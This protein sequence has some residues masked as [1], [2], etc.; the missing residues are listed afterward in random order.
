M[1]LDAL[2]PI[3]ENDGPFATVYLESGSPAEDAEHRIR[4]R[5]DDLRGQLAEAGAE[6]A[7]LEALDGAIM[8]DDITEVLTDGRVLVAGGD[9]VLLEKPWDAALGA[10]DAAHWSSQPE[11]GAYVRERAS[12]V[13][14]LVAITDQEGAVL[15]RVVATQEQ[16][17][18]QIGREVEGSSDA[19][20][21]KPTE[22]A[23]SKIQNR[24]DEAVKRN[25]KD[26]AESLD[27]IARRRGPDVFVLAGEVQGR[28]ALR[29]EL[30]PDLQE[31]LVETDRG[32]TEDDGAEQSLNEELR[33]I[34]GEHAEEVIG[35]THGRFEQAKA[36]DQGV[37]GSDA[38]AKAAQ[39]GAVD[40]LVLQAE[41]AGQDEAR[42]LAAAAQID[43]SVG[44]VA[45]ELQDGVGA[46]LRFEAPAE[47][48]S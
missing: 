4:L 19:P 31:I 33:R 5:W 11:L 7:T 40:T 21:Q 38:V 12:S 47:L 27:R 35:D 3:I 2:K 17:L 37:E 43:A 8:V 46:I 26:I 10:G 34:A 16:T 9:R 22:G 29:D 42:L 18:N 1:K 25:A 28:S 14:M 48:K 23:F 30:S 32:G 45:A 20:V 36:H 24:S 13:D 39:M 44:L 15:R 6:E 41:H